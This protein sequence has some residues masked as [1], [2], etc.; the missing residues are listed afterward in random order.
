MEVIVVDK[1]RRYLPFFCFDNRDA[2][3][4]WERMSMSCEVSK[5]LLLREEDCGVVRMVGM[6]LSNAKDAAV[7]L[8]AYILGGKMALGEEPQSEADSCRFKVL[9]CYDANGIYQ[10]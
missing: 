4:R 10:R 1:Q 6:P 7:Y 8:L 9:A 5:Q 3:N 2:W